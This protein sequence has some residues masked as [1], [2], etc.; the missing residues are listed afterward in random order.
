MHSSVLPLTLQPR[1]PVC[2]AS[3]PGQGVSPPTYHATL[4]G[5]PDASCFSRSCVRPSFFGPVAPMFACWS[6][7]TRL[8]FATAAANLLSVRLWAPPSFSE[9]T[10]ASFGRQLAFQNML[11]PKELH[12]PAAWDSFLSM[13]TAPPAQQATQLPPPHTP[14][15]PAPAHS[16]NQPLT[17]AE[18]EV[19][20]QHLHNGRSGALHGYTSELLRYAQ[21]VATPDDPAP[22]HLLAPCLVVLF[23]AAFST[24]QVP[25]S[26]KTS[27]V[28]PVF[29]RGDATDTA[30]YRPISVGEPISRLYASIM[31]QR[32]VTYTEQQQLRSATQTGYR[33]ELG[34][35]HSAFAL[36]HAVDKHRHASKPLYLC[37]VDLRSAYDKVQWQLLWGLLQRLGVHG[38]MLSAVQSLYDGSLLSMRVNGQ[39]GQ[40]QSP[41]IGL[42]QG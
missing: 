17:L 23:N 15:P 2:G 6:A 34:T 13:L 7:S 21:L 41:S 8:I 27:L 25:Q 14:Q 40:S 12:D 10:R 22:A 33:P 35:I 36:Q 39:C 1:Q 20:L 24:G 4:G 18:I 30:N 16:L 5:T 42:R 38:H 11:L 19:G 31:V 29:K 37:F 9:S 3:N 28:T 26:W 32:L